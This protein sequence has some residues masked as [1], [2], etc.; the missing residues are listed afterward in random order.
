M[1][2]VI[3]SLFY[4]PLRFIITPYFCHLLA[5]QND[6]WF[7]KM[8]SNWARWADVSCQPTPSYLRRGHT[9]GS[10]RRW[11]WTDCDARGSWLEDRDGRCSWR[12]HW[13][14]HTPNTAR[15]STRCRAVGT[16]G[17][18]YTQKHE[19]GRDMKD[20]YGVGRRRWKDVIS[21]GEIIFIDLWML[22]LQRKNDHNDRNMW[23]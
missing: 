9:W 21:W 5:S 1:S 18:V 23:K 14:R 2:D 20:V 19:R 13:S 10:T 4:K 3:L 6:S 7:S 16:G 15:D 8:G 22:R 12:S 17:D 11:A